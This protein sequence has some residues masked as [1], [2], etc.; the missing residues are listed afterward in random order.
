MSAPPALRTWD[1]RIIGRVPKLDAEIVGEADARRLGASDGKLEHPKC[2]RVASPALPDLV[3][4]A[5]PG[6]VVVCRLYPYVRK[7]P[8]SA[9]Y[10]PRARSLQ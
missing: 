4:G 7:R 3:A 1:R 8:K 10:I 9:V 2:E 5:P 6:S